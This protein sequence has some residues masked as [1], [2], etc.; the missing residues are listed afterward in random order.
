MSKPT[1][2]KRKGLATLEFALVM[3]LFLLFC[4]AAV[5]LGA[6][7]RMAMTITSANRAGLQYAGKNSTTAAD[8]TGIANAAKAEAASPAGLSVTS[9]QFCTCSLGGAQVP[10]TNSCTGKI[11]YVQVTTT[12]TYTPVVSWPLVPQP[13]TAM[14]SGAIRVQQ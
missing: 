14:S 11:T 4:M 8:T 6:V 5:D 2:A 3:P 13:L 12:M 1:A 7:F 9:S 10:C